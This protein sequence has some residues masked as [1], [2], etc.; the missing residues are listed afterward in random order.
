MVPETAPHLYEALVEYARAHSSANDTVKVCKSMSVDRISCYKQYCGLPAF[1]LVWTQTAEKA[2]ENVLNTDAGVGL[3]MSE[4]AAGALWKNFPNLLPK[5]TWN[6]L[7]DAYS[8]DRE[9]VLATKADTLFNNARDLKLAAAD[10]QEGMN[11]IY[12][13]KIL[14][15]EFRPDVDLYKSLERARP[16]S[17]FAKEQRKAIKA[18]KRAS[19]PPI[20]D[21]IE[22]FLH[23]LKLFFGGLLSKFHFHVMRIRI[24]IGS[25]DAMTTAMLWCTVSTAL[26]PILIFLDKKSN[27]HGMRNAD[28]QIVTDYLSDKIETD[29]KLA[30]SMSI[31][32]LLGVVFRTGFSFLFGWFKIKPSA[33]Q[34]AGSPAE[35]KSAGAK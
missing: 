25:A 4:T 7:K 8:N 30:F 13:V 32:G 12:H 34:T 19:R 23:V 17:D 22:L 31:G 3:H 29:I 5:S 20:P 6:S 33:P 27:L 21:M 35:A 14:P 16:D 24:K 2:Y 10:E 18:K 28:I 15:A 11:Q 1:K 9:N 26:K